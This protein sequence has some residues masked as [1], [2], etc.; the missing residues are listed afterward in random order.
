MWHADVWHAAQ[1]AR[2]LGNWW[3][4]HEGLRGLGWLTEV[5]DSK[6]D[7]DS[8]VCGVQNERVCAA[9]N[10]GEADWSTVTAKLCMVPDVRYT[11]S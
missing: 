9:Y 10:S 7:V 3:H 1:S 6:V 4:A 8:C 2:W 5:H 11:M